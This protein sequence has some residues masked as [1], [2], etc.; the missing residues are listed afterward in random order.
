MQFR[1][2]CEKRFVCVVWDKRSRAD[3]SL[4][5]PFTKLSQS[6]K[7]SW[8]GGLTP[9]YCFW[10][11]TYSVFVVMLGDGFC[12]FN[13]TSPTLCALPWSNPSAQFP[14]PC[15][16]HSQSK[17]AGMAARSCTPSTRTGGGGGEG[18]REVQGQTQLCLR[19]AWATWDL[20]SKN[21]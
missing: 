1:V 8:L 15:F 17:H 14:Q 19:V 12:V 21:Q 20:A 3:V 10:M 9:V 18:T 4:L 11:W 7:S 16:K 6:S 5:P 13:V 2:V